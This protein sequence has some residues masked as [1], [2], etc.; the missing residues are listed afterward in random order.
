MNIF[1]DTI[2][3]K[4]VFL[5]FDDTRKILAKKECEI[6]WQESSKLIHFFDEFLTENKLTY[7]D[8]T[9]IILVSGPGS[10]TGVRT[11]VLM[12]NTIAFAAQAYLTPIT[13]F[14]LF[15]DFPIIKTSSKRDVFCKMS[16]N[17]DIEVIPNN[18]AILR[19][20]EKKVYSWDFPLDGKRLI[21]SPD[22]EKIIQT[23]E[24]K[25]QKII[26][27]YYIKKPSIS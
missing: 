21:S 22:Y 23:L 7:H 18:E 8:I 27:P 12:V 24:L 16:Q 9:N 13:Y 1:L 26:E 3:P 5:L 11:S 6:L 10:F 14:D 19:L 2:S 25:T 4:W 17:S 15:D 20:E